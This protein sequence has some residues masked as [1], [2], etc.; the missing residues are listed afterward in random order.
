LT[1]NKG[2]E[3]ALA[4]LLALLA[5]AYAWRVEAKPAGATK[6]QVVAAE[7]SGLDALKVGDVSKFA[8]ATADE[9]VF[10]DDRGM[11]TKPEVVRNVNGFTLTD[12][13]M[14][15]IRFVQI[16]PNT[17]LI[18]YNMTENGSSHGHEFTAHVYVSSVWTERGGKWLCLF[19]QETPAREPAK[20]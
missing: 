11:A 20:R 4:V 12:Y 19:S 10:V 13:D 9:A 2:A 6:E 16:A 1:R 5:L 18:S 3:L 14:E 15:D 17:G 7:R 8:S